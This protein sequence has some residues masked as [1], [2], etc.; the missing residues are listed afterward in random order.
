MSKFI[1]KIA[2]IVLSIWSVSSATI[3]SIPDDYTTIQAGINAGSN[4]DTV[5]VRPGTYNE[6]INIYEK[7]LTL[8][9]GFLF[10]EDT[11]DI[12]NTI[13]NGGW[14]GSVIK[15]DSCYGMFMNI[16]G[17]TIENGSAL[18]GGG[19]YCRDSDIKIFH[20]IIKDN[21]VTSTLDST[22][23]GAG[24]ICLNTG[25]SWPPYTFVISEN[26]IKQ[27][28][29]NGFRHKQGY[30]GGVY[31]RVWENTFVINNIFADNNA[32]GM[33]SGGAGICLENS[34]ATLYGNILT[35]NL[36]DIGAGIYI[37]RNS[38]PLVC[39]NVCCNNMGGGITCDTNV[40]ARIINNVII[41]NVWAGGIMCSGN[42][43]P[44]IINNIIRDNQD[45]EIYSPEPLMP[46]TEYNNIAGGYEGEGNIDI[47]PLFRDQ[48][49]GDFHLMALECGDPFD[50]PCID[51]GCPA[52]SDSLLDCKWG[53]GAVRSD[54]GAYSGGDS[55]GVDIDDL[56][57]LPV[58]IAMLQNYPNPFNSSTIISF[59]LPQPQQVRLD[60]YNALGQRV[61]TLVDQFMPAGEHNVAWKADSYS[62]GLYFGRLT[63]NE[64]S[65]NIRMLLVK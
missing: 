56:P 32:S 54:I 9:S 11:L 35:G 34:D 12:V 58:I 3:I 26:I 13:I 50:S 46:R 40:Q 4:G 27:N 5:L 36:S 16:I 29:A 51:A 33:A 57:D 2:L 8:C 43:W 15:I 1:S 62:S 52:L 28:T 14:N 31:L 44:D 61:Q 45:F 6:N 47:D 25:G 21:I 19:I 59:T 49:N 60:F 48:E 17:F 20:N 39:G 65:E 7:S 37:W 38:N 22:G 63:L 55:A 42:S 41:G 18:E 30:G 24:I 64:K 53:L 23:R 10:S